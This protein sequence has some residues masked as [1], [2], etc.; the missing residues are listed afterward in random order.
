MVHIFAGQYQV[1]QEVS[2]AHPYLE[3]MRQCTWIGK[4]EYMGRYLALALGFFWLALFL[5]SHLQ[6]EQ[7]LGQ[8]LFSLFF[9]IHG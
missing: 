8:K 1:M 9:Y 4:Y 5:A 6:N 3:S 7:L 2:I